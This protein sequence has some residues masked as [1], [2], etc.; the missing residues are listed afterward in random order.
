MKLRSLAGVRVRSG[1]HLRWRRICRPAWS[2]R[3]RPMFRHSA[4]PASTSAATSATASV[5]AREPLRALAA[6]SM[7]T[8]SSVGSQI[9]ANYQVARSGCSASKPIYQARNTRQQRAASFAPRQLRHRARRSRL[10]LG[11]LDGV[12]QRRLCLRRQPDRDGSR[13]RHRSSR[14]L[15][16]WSSRCGRRVRSPCELGKLEYL[17]VDLD[18]RNYAFAGCGVGTCRGGDRVDTVRVGVNYRWGGAAPARW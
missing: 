12:W 1:A 14:S 5:R 13:D 7:S 2:P 3:P 16:G 10:C 9:G 6:T 11:S 15:D 17:H 4:G 18:D 8:A